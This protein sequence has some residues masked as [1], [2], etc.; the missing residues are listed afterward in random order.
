MKYRTDLALEGVEELKNRGV[1]PGDKDGIVVY[2]KELE[3]G[4]KATWVEVTSVKGEALVGKPMGNYVTLEVEHLIDEEGKHQELAAKALATLLSKMVKHNYYLKV[5]IVGL[6]NEKVTP[7]S[8]GPVTISKTKVTSHLFRFFDCDGA[9]DMSNVSALAPG[10]SAIT[11]META[12]LIEKAVELTDP[13]VVIAID[14]LAARNMERVSTTVQ[15]TDTGISPGSGMG[16]M[17]KALNSQTLG[18]K[19]IAIGVPTVIDSKT[20]IREAAEEMNLSDHQINEY[21]EN[22]K[23]DMVV[24][25]TD[26][27]LVIKVFSDLIANALNLILHPGIYS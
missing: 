18:R 25:S 24:T 15:I 6:G 17:R 10:V 14:A 2:E 21:F 11:G 8:L 13:D 3:P 7:D 22:R 23:M 12:D 27:D 1:E 16:N 20:V 19:V 4:M 9:E 26:I 5:L